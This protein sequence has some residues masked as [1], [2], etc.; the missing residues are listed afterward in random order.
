MSDTELSQQLIQRLAAALA[1]GGFDPG[2]AQGGPSAPAQVWAAIER[3]LAGDP[4]ASA[5]LLLFASDPA[6]A[7]LQGRLAQALARHIPGEELRALLAALQGGGE[8]AV[9]SRILAD[10]DGLVQGSGH[11]VLAP[12]GP[13]DLETRAG[14]GGR[15]IDSPIVVAGAGAPTPPGPAPTPRREPLPASLS[16]DGVHFSY[17]HA[18]VIGVGQYRDPRIPS[19]ATTANDARALAALLRDPQRAGYPD[20]QVRVLIDA[21][22]TR[23]NILDALEELAQRAAGGTA[24]ICFAGHGETVGG[25]YALLP[26]DAEVGRLTATG[27]DA[28]LFHQPVAKVRERARRLV[29]LLNCCHAG[30]VGDAVLD[31]AAG[32]LSG[33]APPPEFYRPLAQGSGQAVISSSRPSQKSGAVSRRSPQHTTFGA[34]L[35][36]ALG[37]AAPGAGPAVGVFELFAHLRAAVPAD[38]RHIWYGGAPLAQE[39][40]FYASQLDDNLPVALRP[41][42]AGATL[43]VDE[44]LVSRLVALELQIEG[45]GEAAP[46]ELFA[47][48][49][50]LVVDLERI[51]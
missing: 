23:A 25:S 8:P 21:R 10:E 11:R 33:A 12:S 35:L 45:L 27:I 20:A 44:A 18:L 28:A 4:L 29:V 43:G 30:G 40:L 19:V 32:N 51:G 36:D 7:D 47:E 37:G 41:A 42:A 16:A 48:R 34:H 26:H 6:S 49:D 17:G 46:A 24:L 39:P 9:R 2:G 31:A 13:V 15:I 5:A 1:A 14:K 50:G 22:A 38:A 3:R